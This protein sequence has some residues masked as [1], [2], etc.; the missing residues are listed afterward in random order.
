MIRTSFSFQCLRND[1]LPFSPFLAMVLCLWLV[2]FM[3][4]SRKTQIT[5]NYSSSLFLTKAPSSLTLSLSSQQERNLISLSIIFFL[6]LLAFSCV[7]ED[8]KIPFILAESFSILPVPQPSTFFSTSLQKRCH[9]IYS[10]STSNCISYFNF[11][12]HSTYIMI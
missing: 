6:Y 1:Y 9:V 4:I 8:R 11:Y 12:L 10:R 5:S 3:F 7:W 2:L